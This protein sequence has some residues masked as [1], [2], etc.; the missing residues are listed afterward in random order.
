MALTLSDI[1]NAIIANAK[2]T[3][4][5][6]TLHDAQISTTEDELIA[7]GMPLVVYSYQTGIVDDTLLASFT[8]AKL[9]AVGI[10]TTGTVT[11]T[12]PLDEVF[13]M[14]LA[15]VTVN[16]TGNN[17]V[18]ITVMGRATLTLVTN[19]QS[20][21]TVKMYNVSTATVTMNDTSM[22][23]IESK[24]DNAVAIIQNDASVINITTSGFS[25]VTLATHNT[26]YAFAKMY[27]SSA[28]T[29]RTYDTSSVQAVKF[30]NATITDTTPAP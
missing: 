25:N 22:V 4:I 13:I 16:V 20:W 21:A 11:L 24:D 26:S 15:H 3:E 23:S 14:K 28:V 18:K 6:D 12:N 10:Y 30:N 29:F 8:E 19:D 2:A 5:C 17:K 9:N 7:A 1:K 27:H